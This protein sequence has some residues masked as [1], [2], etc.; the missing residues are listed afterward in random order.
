[1][2][3]IE[4]KKAIVLIFMYEGHLKIMWLL[5]LE[6]VPQYLKL[7]SSVICVTFVCVIL[8]FNVMH[9]VNLLRLLLLTWYKNYVVGLSA[10]MILFQFG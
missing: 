10:S 7:N 9:T 6:C 2:K 4:R 8:F 1:M 5:L 3:K